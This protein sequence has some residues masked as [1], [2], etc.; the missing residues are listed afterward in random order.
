[1]YVTFDYYENTYK[2]TEVDSVSF[3]SYELKARMIVK[4]YALKPEHQFERVLQGEYADSLR[5]T[6]CELIDSIKNFETLLETAKKGQL[7]QISGVA[8]ES[9]KDHSITVAKGN[10]DSV[11]ELENITHNEQIRIM[12]KYLLVTGLLYRGL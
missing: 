9:V 1:M 2:G 5:L 6:M 10:V 12:R 8:S 3:P 11:T 4:G 7:R